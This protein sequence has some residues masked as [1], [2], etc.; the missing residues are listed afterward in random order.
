MLDQNTQGYAFFSVSLG[1]LFSFYMVVIALSGL[2]LAGCW[3]WHPMSLAVLMLLLTVVEIRCLRRLFQVKGLRWHR[4]EG[5][6]LVLLDRVVAVQAVQSGV[7]TRP[8]IWL[9]VMAD[10]GCCYTVGYF[11]WFSRVAALSQLR[12]LLRC[13]QCDDHVPMLSDL[14]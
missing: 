8:L 10:D 4:H 13:Q 5:W 12:F 9:R 14:G 3:P 7:V 2:L 1:E 11:C 6:Q